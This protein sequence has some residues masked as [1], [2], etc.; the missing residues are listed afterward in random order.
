MNDK[1]NETSH[2]IQERL[3]NQEIS[4]RKTIQVKPN[5]SPPSACMQVLIA[6]RVFYDKEI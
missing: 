3:V 6:S 2:A 5:I 4:K 1:P